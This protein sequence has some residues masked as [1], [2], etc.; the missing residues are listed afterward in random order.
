[1]P[2]I[3]AMET[4]LVMIEPVDPRDI[5]WEADSPVS[6]SPCGISHPCLLA[7]LGRRRRRDL[8]ACSAWTPPVRPSYR[9]RGNASGPARTSRR[10]HGSGAAASHLPKF[11]V[12]SGRRAGFQ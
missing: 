1:M 3:A 5:Q 2:R 9:T 12:V 10:V 7:S 4:L 8:C 11:D 6:A